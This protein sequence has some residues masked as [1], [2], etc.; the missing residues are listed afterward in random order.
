MKRGTV[1][2]KENV[3]AVIA[4]S[5][6]KVMLDQLLVGGAPY[7]FR[8]QWKGL[9][10]E[11][12]PASKEIGFAIEE[13]SKGVFQNVPSDYDVE[14]QFQIRKDGTLAPFFR[15]PMMEMQRFA[16]RKE[17]LSTSTAP[18]TAASMVALSKKYMKKDAQIIDPFCGVGTLLIERHRALHAREI[19]GL[20]TFGDAIRAARVNTEAAGMHANYINR[21]YF[22]FKHDYLFDE[23]ITEFP[24]LYSKEPKEREDFYQA[25]F[26]KT[27]E[28]T[29]DSA[30]LILLSNEEKLLKKLMRLS[31]DYTLEQTIAFRKRSKIFIIRRK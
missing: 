22:D 10:E 3:G 2:T 16:Y 21:D 17:A 8:I 11:H 27:K 5:K 26:R 12:K 31:S 1:M 23:V 18:L 6:M 15:L 9:P 19:Y 28:I 25:F 7:R 4:E 14:L 24:D 29:T 13:A 20:D 30:V